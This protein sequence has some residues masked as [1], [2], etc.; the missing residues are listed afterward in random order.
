MACEL[1]LIKLFL[2]EKKRKGKTLKN[3]GA[4]QLCLWLAPEFW[5]R[6]SFLLFSC[7]SFSI[8]KRW[9]TTLLCNVQLKGNFYICS[10]QHLQEELKATNAIQG[11]LALVLSFKEAVC[12]FKSIPG[13]L[14]NVCP[15]PG[16]WGL[17]GRLALLSENLLEGTMPSEIWF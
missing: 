13:T 12:G 9:L 10:L 1:Y 7:L 15:A 14:S 17:R 3:L 5:A 11:W 8:S 6:Y 2:K 4:S 16:P